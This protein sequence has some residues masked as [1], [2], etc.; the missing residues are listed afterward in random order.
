MFVVVQVALGR[1]CS[2]DIA[3]ALDGTQWS[4]GTT[5][6]FPN[7]AKFNETTERW[8]VYSPPTYFAAVSPSDEGAVVK[9]VRETEFILGSLRLY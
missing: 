2:M 3:K 8:T 1:L 7:S 6:S 4:A 9:A 5:V